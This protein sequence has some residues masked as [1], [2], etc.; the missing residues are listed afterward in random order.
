MQL[1]CSC[2]RSLFWSVESGI[3]KFAKNTTHNPVYNRSAVVD[4]HIRTARDELKSHMCTSIDQS[5]N[6]KH[7]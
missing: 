5:F 3:I 4:K 1:I 7:F 2:V 6:F